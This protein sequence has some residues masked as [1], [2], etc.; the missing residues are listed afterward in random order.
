MKCWGDWRQ[1]SSSLVSVRETSPF[2]LPSPSLPPSLPPYFSVPFPP[3]QFVSF[4]PPPSP[5]PHKRLGKPLTTGR[6]TTIYNG[7]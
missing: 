2:L 7:I 4:S 1:S 6:L 3:P 5:P